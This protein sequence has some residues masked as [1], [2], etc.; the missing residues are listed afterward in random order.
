MSQS[1]K[2]TNRLFRWSW[3]PLAFFL[4][5]LS[6]F[7]FYDTYFFLSPREYAPMQHWHG[8][9]SFLWVIFLVTQAALISTGRRRLH[10]RLGTV[11]FPFAVFLILTT[12][13]ISWDS[14]AFTGVTPGST[15]ILAIRLWLLIMFVAFLTLAFVKRKTPTEHARWMICSA[16]ILIDPVLNRI[17][18]NFIDWSY[19]TGIHQFISFGT[20]NMFLLVLAF[21]DFRDGR[22][23]IFV[24][25]LAIMVP[26]QIFVFLIWDTSIWTDIANAFLA[27]PIGAV[28]GTLG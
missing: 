22:K 11:Y 23:D 21:A 2:T 8:I 24:S 17:S 14:L 15:Y 7:A 6:L 28:P 26:T 18:D 9:T 13:V 5:F 20:M 12:I 1:S 4:P 19:T 25:A 10:R 3:I 16:I 27:L